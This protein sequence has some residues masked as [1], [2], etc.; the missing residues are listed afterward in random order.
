[1]ENYIANKQVRKKLS[2]WHLY[3][4][5]RTWHI[6]LN[7]AY[8]RH[9]AQKVLINFPGGE[10]E[11]SNKYICFCNFLKSWRPWNRGQLRNEGVVERK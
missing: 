2:C 9:S 7:D 10:H 5:I 4:S 11:P 1:V 3:T 6:Q 8:M